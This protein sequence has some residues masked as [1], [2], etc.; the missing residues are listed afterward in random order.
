MSQ[1]TQDYFNI[2]SIVCIEKK[3]PVQSAIEYVFVMLESAVRCLSDLRSQIPKFDPQT[4]G[5]V[6]IYFEGLDYFIG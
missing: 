3:I 4:D 2:V 6:S 5:I 1:Y